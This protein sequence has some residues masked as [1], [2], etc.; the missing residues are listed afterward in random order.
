ME[1]PDDV[2]TLYTAKL[3]RDGGRAVFD[4]PE[5]ELEVGDLAVGD[6]YRVAVIPTDGASTDGQSTG[7]RSTTDRTPT[8]TRAGAEPPVEEG[9]T[10][11]VEIEDVGDQ[12]DGIARIGPGYVVFVPDTAV[13]D[14]V[15]VEINEARDNFAF[16]EVVESEPLS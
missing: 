2:M 16:G 8:R 6:R 12:G 5:H 7:S 1:L 15:T 10:R 4:V 13:G 3:K 14:R 9:E 11:E